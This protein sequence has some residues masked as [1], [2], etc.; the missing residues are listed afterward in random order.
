MGLGWRYPSR[1]K[2]SFHGKL[3]WGSTIFYWAF[4]G[5]Q[6]FV[7]EDPIFTLRRGNKIALHWRKEFQ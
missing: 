7:G 5:T 4:H 2:S 6:D 3:Q 1:Q